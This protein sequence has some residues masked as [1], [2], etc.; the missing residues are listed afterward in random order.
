MVPVEA[1]TPTCD[2]EKLSEEGSRTSPSETETTLPGGED[3]LPAIP[4]DHRVITKKKEDPLGELTLEHQLFATD[5]PFF[6]PWYEFLPQY[7]TQK[8]IIAQS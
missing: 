7:T 2:S 6:L 8:T 3:L 1:R 5:F 4:S